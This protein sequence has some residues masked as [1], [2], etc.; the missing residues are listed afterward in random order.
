[1]TPLRRKGKSESESVRRRAVTLA[2]FLARREKNFTCEYCGRR[3]PSV[4]THGSH[5]YSE[6]VHRSMSADLDNILCLCATCHMTGYWNRTNK[7]NWHGTPLEAIEWFKAKYPARYETLKLR[8]QKS[9]QADEQF[10]RKK[11]EELKTL[12]NTG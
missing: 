12:E 11:L 8:S 6:G 1:M 2:K 4:K 10:W 7:W 9:V 3:E 5:V